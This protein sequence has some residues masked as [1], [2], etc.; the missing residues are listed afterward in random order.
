MGPA[1]SQSAQ[2]CQSVKQMVSDRYG[3]SP[4][5][6]L[7]R[8]QCSSCA[9]P[10]KSRN[11]ISREWVVFYY[12][13]VMIRSATLR[14]RK[15]SVVVLLPACFSAALVAR[16]PR[17][18]DF[19]LSHKMMSSMLSR[20]ARQSSAG[21]AIEQRRTFAPDAKCRLSCVESL[22]EHQC[23]FFEAAISSPNRKETGVADSKRRWRSHQRGTQFGSRLADGHGGEEHVQSLGDGGVRQDRVAEFLVW[24][25]PR[26]CHLDDG[27]HFPR[28][29]SECR[30][31]E[32]AIVHCD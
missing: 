31:P 15:H 5:A 27:H 28:F 25:P 3:K 8:L 18:R 10:T 4:E 7:C 13:I 32:N 29:H 11:G 19:G 20:N 1:V 30:E 16:G 14:N 22:P 6:S 12:N 26:H 23:R 2:L 9:S 24:H 21:L 17:G